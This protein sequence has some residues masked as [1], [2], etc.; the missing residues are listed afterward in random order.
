MLAGGLRVCLVGGVV[1]LSS[2]LE[3]GSSSQLR[4]HHL[5][6][7]MGSMNIERMMWNK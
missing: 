2:F 3:G 6:S 1:G 7:E 4:N 5:E